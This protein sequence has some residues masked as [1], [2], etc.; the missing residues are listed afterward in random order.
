LPPA[1]RGDLLEAAKE[2]YYRV[3]EAEADLLSL[4]GDGD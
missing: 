2:D 1:A 3:I 4:Q